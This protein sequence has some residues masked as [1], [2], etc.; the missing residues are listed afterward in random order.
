M[1]STLEKPL[2]LSN[3]A[4]SYDILGEFA[5]SNHTR[6]YQARRLSDGK[7]VLITVLEAS[8]DVAQGKAIAQF[9]ADANLLTK[10][11]HPNVPRVVE[12]R[13]IGDGAFAL[14][15]E[16]IQG[17]TLAEQL[18][19]ERLTKPR[20][21][22]ILGDVDGVLNW[23]RGERL[24]HRN[25]TPESIWVE[26]GT[27]KVFVILSPTE[28]PKTNRPDARDDARTIGQLAMAMLTAKP[29]SEEHDGS[30]FGMRPDL[31]ERVATATEKVAACTINDETPDIPAFLASLAMADAIKEGELEVAR[32]DAEFRAQLK[33]EREKWEAEQEACRLSNENQAK[34]FAEE[35]AEY[36]RRSAKER[37]QLVDAR[38]EI[39][40]RSTELQAA[41]TELDQARAAYKQKKS[42]LESRAKLVDKHMADLEKQ[43]RNLEKRAAE[44]ARH[45]EELEAKNKELTALAALATAAGTQ[46]PA[47]LEEE[48][49]S[50]M[51]LEQRIEHVGEIN[52]PTQ[53]VPVVDDPEFD[54]PAEDDVEI[55]SNA[56]EAEIA[57]PDEPVEPWSPIEA[58][59]PWAVPLET[60]EPVKAI[61]YEAAAVP[62][63]PKK[64]RPAWAVPAGIAGAVVLLVGS[65]LAINHQKSEPTT[66]VA[67]TTQ[68]APSNTTT[69][70]TVVTP[71][72]TTVDSAAGSIAPTTADSSF[73]A[74]RD[75][76]AAADEARRARLERQA[77]QAQ[78][79]KRA[80]APRTYTDSTG[81]IWYYDR[82]PAGQ[83][84]TSTPPEQ[85]AS[86]TTVP[87][88]STV[89]A[90]TTPALT[91]P[92]PAAVTP[93]AVP[94]PDSMIKA[95]APKLDSM[96]RP[97]PDTGRCCS[98]R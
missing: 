75:S 69:P 62:E 77:E 85:S 78:A 11:S 40:K 41:R 58:A 25:V 81:K 87:A 46:V 63:K 29:M 24:S 84:Q 86:T 89:P 31:P 19:G 9:A 20:I 8:P 26:R 55:I 47:P 65:A 14:V 53:P 56:V 72:T 96:A 48:E 71:T 17:T 88:T 82:P 15:T 60:D 57:Q 5:G 12:A 54:E 74:L 76:I 34:K 35:R 64:S 50:G 73:A 1:S 80:A 94:K 93:P 23:A 39:D 51:T 37:Q 44:L 6:T 3:L 79:E 59:E 91:T 22:A 2:D 10:I 95:I 21:A 36:E 52:R 45:A 28:A 7:D 92:T 4:E 43:K 83:Q 61:T 33:A 67:T 13:W 42:E 30:L 98:N 32:V 27:G 68:H 16:R 90:V 49:V 38:G 66:T 18:K 97:K 70:T